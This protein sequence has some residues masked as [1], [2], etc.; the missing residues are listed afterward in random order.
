MIYKKEIKNFNKKLTDNVIKRSILAFT[1][2]MCLIVPNELVLSKN[3]TDAEKEK[4]AKEVMSKIEIKN[5][6]Q[7][8]IIKNS[9]GINIYVIYNTF[10]KANNSNTPDNMMEQ[11]DK[12]VS[13]YYSET[14]GNYFDNG[15]YNHKIEILQLAKKLNL[16]NLLTKMKDFCYHPYAVCEYDKFSKEELQELK[17]ELEK[18]FDEYKEVDHGGPTGFASNSVIANI[19]SI[20]IAIKNYNKEKHKKYKNL[21]TYMFKDGVYDKYFTLAKNLVN[22]YESP[23][24]RSYKRTPV[25]RT[26][27]RNIKDVGD[28]YEA[29]LIIREDIPIDNAIGDKIN[30]NDVVVIWTCKKDEMKKD[31]SLILKCTSKYEYEKSADDEDYNKKYFGHQASCFELIKGN[32]EYNYD[33]WRDGWDSDDYEDYSINYEQGKYIL[34]EMEV[35]A[36]EYVAQRVKMNLRILKD[37]RVL[38]SYFLDSIDKPLSNNHDYEFKEKFKDVVLSDIYNKNI[39]FRYSYGKEFYYPII[40]KNKDDEEG[41]YGESYLCDNF[42]NITMLTFDEKGY[43]TG[44]YKGEN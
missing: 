9:D 38:G 39:Y 5:D 2:M 35:E 21:S 23:Y 20:D 1:F 44:I 32:D 28:Y 37:A 42:Q 19:K 24:E 27:I 31:N 14:G 8:E 15:V 13:Y 30:E 10:G 34:E 26:E 6:K 22:V 25:N 4:T 17:K 29:D 16:N 33:S 41:E 12:D 43:I 7:Y 3:M 40:A 18:V 36:A 11:V